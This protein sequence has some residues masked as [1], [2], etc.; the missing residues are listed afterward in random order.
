LVISEFDSWAE[1]LADGIQRV[2][3]QNIEKAITDSFSIAI[4]RQST[5]RQDFRVDI[6]MRHFECPDKEVCELRI[7]WCVKGGNDK[8][9]SPWVK[10]KIEVSSVSMLL[11]QA[12]L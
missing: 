1:P 8:I 12:L 11:H 6:V 3:M 5:E 10:S 7:R 2:I 4:A 9:L